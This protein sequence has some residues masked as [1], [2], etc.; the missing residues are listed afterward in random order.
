MDTVYRKVFC[1]VAQCARTCVRERVCDTTTG[2]TC[3]GFLNFQ[4]AS[5]PCMYVLEEVFSNTDLMEQANIASIFDLQTL[6]M[7]GM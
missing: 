3:E 5:E 2:H 4:E 1:L 7:E 6:L